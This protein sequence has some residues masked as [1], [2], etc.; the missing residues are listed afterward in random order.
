MKRNKYVSIFWIVLGAVLIVCGGAGILDEYWS[1][2][3]GACAV[4][5]S[6]QMVRYVRISRNEAY[7]EKIETES[8]DERN[9]YLG[10]KAWA[11]AGYSYVIIAALASIGLRIAGK[12][13]LSLLV[14][15]S[16]CLILVLYCASYYIL[17][18]KY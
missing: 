11:W 16:M 13:D 3:G 6:L 7:R 10:G 14:S 18:R 15:G 12:N 9:R 2:M 1:S 8:R 4:V 17:R 5:G